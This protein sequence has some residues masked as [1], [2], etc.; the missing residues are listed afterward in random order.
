MFSQLNPQT[1]ATALWHDWNVRKLTL[2]RQYKLSKWIMDA[3]NYEYEQIPIKIFL[4]EHFL[5]QS[6]KALILGLLV[7]EKVCSQSLTC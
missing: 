4:T 7:Y 1:P 6:A 2:E 3:L 5:N